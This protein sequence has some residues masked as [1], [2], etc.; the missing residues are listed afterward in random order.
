[1]CYVIIEMSF[2]EWVPVEGL[3]TGVYCMPGI[4]MKN[5]A[6]GVLQADKDAEGVTLLL[7]KQCGTWAY[8]RFIKKMINL[9]NDSVR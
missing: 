7:E 4:L 2:S 5:E 9:R 8:F 1:M 6:T 3:Y